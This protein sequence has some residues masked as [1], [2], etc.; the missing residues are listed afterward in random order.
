[1]Q[2]ILSDLKM[3]QRSCSW[4]T[5]ASDCV[6]MEVEHDFEHEILDEVT[7]VNQTSDQIIDILIRY[8][9]HQLL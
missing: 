9:T 5:G 7:P 8:S 1:M 2:H 4:K 3:E 6:A